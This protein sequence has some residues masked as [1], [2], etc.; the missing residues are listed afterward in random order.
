M[1]C[2]PYIEQTYGQETLKI[3]QDQFEFRDEPRVAEETLLGTL[4]LGTSVVWT[5]KTS[6]SWF[7]VKAPN[8]Q[9]GWVHESGLSRPT[10]RPQP[11]APQTSRSV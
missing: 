7:E 4:R 5:G 11:A 9:I 1:L 6:G 2:F 8:G 10:T 3:T